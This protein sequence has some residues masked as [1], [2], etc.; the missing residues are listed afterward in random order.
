MGFGPHEKAKYFKPRRLTEGS[1]GSQCMGRGHP[2]RGRDRADMA[3]N[4]QNASAH[5]AFLPNGR[6]MT[7]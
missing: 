2:V 1:Q 7:A 4:R 6:L 3:N 5:S